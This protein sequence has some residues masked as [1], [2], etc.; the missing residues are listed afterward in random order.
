MYSLAVPD[1]ASNLKVSTSGGSGD[2]DVYVK[3]GAAPSATSYDC[4]SATAGTNTESCTISNVQGGT[5][6]ILIQ[7]KAAYSG[8]ALTASFNK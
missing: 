4:R 1:G 2:A 6:Q 8:I 3:F 5:Y 7:A